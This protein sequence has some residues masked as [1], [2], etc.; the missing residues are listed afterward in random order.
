MLHIINQFPIDTSELAQAESGDIVV[1]TE[2]AVLAVK[3]RS[4]IG[5]FIKKALAHINLCVS[6]TDLKRLG[7]GMSDLLC[8]VSILDDRDLHDITG[9]EL[10]IRSWN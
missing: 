7:L 8:G 2:N 9:N 3:R 1:F 6:G 5:N 10:A 4:E